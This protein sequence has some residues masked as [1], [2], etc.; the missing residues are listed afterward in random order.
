MTRTYVNETIYLYKDLKMEKLEKI[1][2]FPFLIKTKTLKDQKGCV[3]LGILYRTN[4]EQRKINFLEE[5]KNKEI[6]KYLPL[7]F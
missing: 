1:E 4:K 5:L 7:D 3:S 6:N 2:D